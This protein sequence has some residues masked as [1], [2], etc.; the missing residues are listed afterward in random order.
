[1]S[2][3]SAKVHMSVSTNPQHLE[4]GQ[5]EARSLELHRGLP[6]DGRGQSSWNI[7]HCFPRCICRQLD[8]KQS[9]YNSDCSSVC[10]ALILD[11]SLACWATTLAPTF[12]FIKWSHNLIILHKRPS[13]PSCWPKVYSLNLEQDLHQ[14]FSLDSCHLSF[15]L[16]CHFPLEK[17][18]GRGHYRRESYAFY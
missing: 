16:W 8:Q 2:S 5:A 9:M 1:M 14:H 4:L 15:L 11:G 18:K 3:E 17:R 6:M 7:F 12:V 10:D 13:P